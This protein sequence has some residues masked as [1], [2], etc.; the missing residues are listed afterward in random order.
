MIIMDWFLKINKEE[1]PAGNNLYSIFAYLS[2]EGDSTDKILNIHQFF[3]LIVNDGVLP[4]FTCSCGDFECGGQF[5]E[6]EKIAEGFQ[7]S[8]LF[9]RNNNFM[10]TLD[11]KLSW[12]DM[13]II[14]NEIIEAI[15]EID[16]KYPDVSI[17][18]GTMGDDLK[19]SMNVF[20][21]KIDEYIILRDK[22]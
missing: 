21:E 5:V 18:N 6:I 4:L 1:S 10:R 17:C 13:I 7:L 9:D 14:G 8:K 12:D 11:F 15:S 3:N 16:H 22:E 20:R 2:I 19:E